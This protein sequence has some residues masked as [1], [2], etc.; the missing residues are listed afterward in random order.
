MSRC[1]GV[2]VSCSC[3]WSCLSYRTRPTA[4]SWI[5]PV[6]T[7]KEEEERKGIGA[8]WV[9][10]TGL[11]RLELTAEHDTRSLPS[12]S[13]HLQQNDM[14]RCLGQPAPSKWGLL[15][16]KAATAQRGSSLTRASVAPSRRHVGIMCIYSNLARSTLRSEHYHAGRGCGTSSCRRASTQ[17][18]C[19]GP[20]CPLGRT[21]RYLQVDA[22]ALIEARVISSAVSTSFLAAL[23]L[24]LRSPAPLLERAQVAPPRRASEAGGDRL[25]LTRKPA[26][27]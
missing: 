7:V 1:R 10:R 5:T 13:S 22:A 23:S 9:S 18:M 16:K 27:S 26:R 19:L 6:P 25:R 14:P 21:L 20:L 3:S 24:L 11:Y 12:L 4:S 2:A 8:P 17:C 15:Q